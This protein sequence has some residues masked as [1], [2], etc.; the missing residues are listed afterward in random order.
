MG[1]L[2]G[3]RSTSELCEYYIRDVDLKVHA[4]SPARM[5]RRLPRPRLY[6]P[7]AIKP[8]KEIHHGALKW[9]PP[10]FMFGLADK[11]ARLLASP[12]SH[13]Y[14]APTDSPLHPR[15]V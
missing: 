14:L 12:G 7:R 3:W 15:Q 4:R 5:R 1:S 2:G 10:T 11:Y 6:R 9:L 8:L 13:P